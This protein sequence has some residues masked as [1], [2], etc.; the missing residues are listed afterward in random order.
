MGMSAVHAYVPTTW[1]RGVPNNIYS[2]LGAI[3]ASQELDTYLPCN[4]DPRVNLFAL[5]QRSQHL[6]GQ[7]QAYGLGFQGTLYMDK[8]LQGLYSQIYAAALMNH[9]KI[10]DQ[11]FRVKQ[12][13][14]SSLADTHLALGWKALNKKRLSLSGYLFGIIPAPKH[15]LFDP[16]KIINW[17]G[18]DNHFAWG[19]GLDV[20][21]RL[22]GNQ[23]HHIDWLTDT[24]VTF[25][26][27][28]HAQA[29]KNNSGYE[30]CPIKIHAHQLYKCQSTIAY[31]FK[32]FIS[33]LGIQC[34]YMPAP[35]YDMANG[36]TKSLTPSD[37]WVSFLCDIGVVL[38]VHQSSLYCSLGAQVTDYNHS[39][40]MWS[41]NLKC[42]IRF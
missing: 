31:Q 29:W 14:S 11:S 36:L 3:N 33:D 39:F 4:F 12:D 38:P 41:A 28:R 24:N 34:F 9:G 42:G 1:I 10:H 23:F 13:T 37:L 5:T 26:T 22:W 30:L 40:D 15:A 18:L 25:L 6:A 32:N 7:C 17:I 19:T 27:S 20:F 2:P 35:H 21:V 8:V 16:N